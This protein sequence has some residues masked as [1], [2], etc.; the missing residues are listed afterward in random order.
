MIE[1]F[2]P[3]TKRDRDTLAEEGERLVRFAREDAE[4]SEIRFAEP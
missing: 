2:G 3:L 4:A 1:P